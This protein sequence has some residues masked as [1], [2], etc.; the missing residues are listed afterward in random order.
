MT[1]RPAP[2]LPLSLATPTAVL[3]CVAGCGL[4]LWGGLSAQDP[5]ERFIASDDVRHLLCFAILG[6]CAGLLRGRGLRLTGLLIVLCLAPGLEGLQALTP[7][8]TPALDDA[9]HSVLGGL[10]GF[11]LLSWPTEIRRRFIHA[12]ASARPTPAFA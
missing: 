5:L 9:G 12:R 8:R 11:I 3:S 1:R 4:I 10:L 2:P 7:G 6:A